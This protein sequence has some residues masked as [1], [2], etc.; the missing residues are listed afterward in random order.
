MAVVK[1]LIVRI[2]ADVSGVVSGMKT[3]YA[4]TRQATS[5]IKA[6][7]ADVKKAVKSGFS[8][9]RVS[10][11][12]YR[13]AV[14][15]LKSSHS[16]AAQNVERL[17]DKLEY[18]QSSF[19]TVKD[20]TAGLDISTPLAT[21]I[22]AAEKSWQDLGNEAQKTKDALKKALSDSGDLDYSDKVASLRRDLQLLRSAS[23]EAK[24]ELDGLRAVAAQIGEENIDFASDAGMKNL[25]SEIRQVQQDLNV[26]K[27]KAGELGLKL[28]SLRIP[29]LI[30]S[31]LKSIGTAASSA[32]KTGAKKLGT[33]LKNL[34]VSGARDFSSIPLRLLGIGKSASSGTSGLEKM[35]RSIRRIGVV[36]LGMRAVGSVFRGAF[37]TIR[38]IVSSYISDN[39]ELSGIITNMKSQLGQALAPAINAVVV[40]LQ[41]LMPVIQAIASAVSSIFTALFGKLQSTTS[42]IK[43][44]AS[45]AASAA[46]QLETYGFDQITKQSDS[47]SNSGSSGSGGSYNSSATPQWLESIL[48]WVDK[49]KSAFASGNWKGL[50]QILGSG[51][52][53]AVESINSV[54]LGAKAGTF[55]NN[56]LS[57]L[58]SALT[59]VDWIGIGR[60][61]GEF[62]TSGVGEVDWS[63]VGATVGNALTLLPS[64]VTGAIGAIDWGLVASSL[65]NG[66]SSALS[67]VS[68][69][70]QKVDWQG[71]GHGIWEFVANIDYGSIAN[72]LFSL[73]GSAIGASVGTLWGFISGAAA[74]IQNFFAERMEEC[75]GN[76]VLGLLKGI[77]DGL[78]NI[79]EWII[80]NILE[81]FVTGFCNAFGIHSPSTVM[82]EKGA[83]L[84]LGVL[85]GLQDKWDEVVNFFAEKLEDIKSTFSEKWSEIRDS[86][87]QKWGEI[88]TAVADKVE[89]LKDNTMKKFG[90]VR[91]SVSNTWANIRSNT[92]STW[93]QV[94]SSMASKLLRVKGDTESKLT[95]V[96]NKASEIWSGVKA[97]T[98][99]AASTIS[100]AA[101]TG[102]TKLK[103]GVVQVFSGLW[104]SVKTWINKLIGG[105]ESMVNFI[106]RG[107]NNLI[108][109]LNSVAKIGE[110]FGLSI[111]I[112][113]ISTIS[114]PRLA[115]GGIA[116][117]PTTA[118]IGEAG[119]EAV[120]PLERNT[121]WM[122]QLAAKITASRGGDRPLILQL[123][124]GG[125][126]ITEYVIKDINQI[127]KTTGSCPIY[128]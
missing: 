71:I 55:V 118:L 83:Y 79:G 43:S 101:I 54:D 112:S 3:A 26:S 25:K 27:L 21:Q 17:Q 73:L 97:D 42:G 111:S 78:V 61:V 80:T 18:L 74:S 125:R 63:T 106:I 86:T 91:S 46:D 110:K 92:T 90:A 45:A 94:R 28:N 8:G 113:R 87:S 13:E 65:S 72:S 67:A 32:A 49:L 124:V 56:L 102:F 2:G 47:D 37:G 60:K 68:S 105:V 58:N 24:F 62:V 7:T 119:K 39:E 41:R 104:S 77:G 96:R 36:A 84:V 64:I 69:F 50:G 127:T 38:S 1:N 100:S 48:G 10:I 52:N 81:P 33:T 29:N 15:S 31:E 75:G 128:I 11:Q 34:A 23:D 109:P 123:I 16:A 66:L 120:L 93:E 44:S 88:K 76:V 95:D 121:G 115:K 85:Q 82:A 89:D 126:K 53:S 6:A 57:A 4:S 59:T 99:T 19:E 14:S 117:G 40:V 35:V 22:Q 103:T 70:Y 30:K 20:A 98:A 108:E 51:I 12:E 5:Q 116:V 107:I 114:L 9:S 122:E